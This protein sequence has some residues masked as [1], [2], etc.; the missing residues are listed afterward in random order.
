[1]IDLNVG[2]PSDK[3]RD[4]RFGAVLMREPALVADCLAAMIRASTAE[5]GPE[6]TVKC[7]LGV[8]EQ[9]PAETLP[10]FLD[11]CA[12]AGV[13][14]VALH[15]RKAWLKGLSPKQNRDVP[16]LDPDLAW[17]MKARRPELQIALNGGVTSLDE[18]EAHLARGFDGVMIG[19]A[20][21]HDPGAILAAADRRIFGESGPDADEA[22][23]ALAMIPYIEAE[24][25]RGEKLHRIT[26]H[27]QGLFNGRRGARAWRRT[28]SEGAR[29]PGAGPELIES[30]LAEIAPL[31]A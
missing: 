11:R 14:H 30:A 9:E 2:C 17:E 15:A 8:D 21:Y 6:V 31:A 27:M 1:E 4:G 25:A 28:L 29:A 3:V 7:R 20:A 16:P 10:F 13:R 12:D 18:A 24:L 22:A 23:A 26:R 5:G 19:R